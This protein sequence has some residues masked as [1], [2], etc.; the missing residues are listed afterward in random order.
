VNEFDLMKH[1]FLGA[2]LKRIRY[3]MDSLQ[4][5]TLKLQSEFLFMKIV[6]TEYLPF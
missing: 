5:L 6:T 1:L 3:K 2:G 4:S